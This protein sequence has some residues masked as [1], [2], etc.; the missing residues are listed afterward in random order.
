MEN[1]PKNLKDKWTMAHGYSSKSAQ[2]EL[3]HEYQH[4]RQGLRQDF[5]N[6]VSKMGFQED[7]VSKPLTEKN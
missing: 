5:Q 1:D 2:R 6:R 7:R 4:D 3:S